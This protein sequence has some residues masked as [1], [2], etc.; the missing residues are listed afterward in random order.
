MTTKDSSRKQII[1]SMGTNNI[2]RVIVQL[3][4]HVANINRLLKDIKLEVSV[5]FI[6]S[7]NKGIIVTTN[8]IA[9]ISDLNVVEEYMKNLNDIN[10]SNIISFRFL[11]SK[12]YLKI[13]DIPYCIKN[14]NLLITMDIVKRVIQ[15]TYI[16]NSVILASC[17]LL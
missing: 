1:I 2:E 6:W 9:V 14:N 7:D 16:F 8:K 13:L 4:I 17:L 11:Q 10:S 5:D 3:N 15:T 12:S